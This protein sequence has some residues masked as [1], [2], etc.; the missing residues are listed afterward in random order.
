MRDGKPERVKKSTLS[1][2]FE[3]TNK[4]YLVYLA[5][6]PFVAISGTVSF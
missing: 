4:R 6:L 5:E 1:I 2:S 3:F